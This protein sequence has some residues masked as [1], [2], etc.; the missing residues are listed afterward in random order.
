MEFCE[1]V[2]KETDF[3]W[4]A[5]FYHPF[6]Q[7]I[8]DGSLPLEKFKFY[9]LQDAYYLKH[10]TKVL[11]LAAAKA[12]TDDDVQ[13]FLQTA[14]FIH[15]AELELHRTTFKELGVT[16]DDVEHFEPAPA[17]Y[18]YVSHMYNAVHNGDV[19]EAFAAIL[20]CPWLY[21]E[22]GQRLKDA[23]PNVPL[24][25]Q[26]IALYASDEMLQNIEIQKSMLNRYAKEQ[27][28]KLKVLQEHFKRSCYYEWMFWEMPWTKQSWEQGVYVNEPAGNS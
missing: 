19:A 15:D 3:Y 12:T 1:K 8:A 26:W 22:I 7:G 9:M 6:V 2:R 20:P 4:E 16:A 13:Y 14:K 21:Q 25:D 18:N 10:Y 5:S 27:P 11:A 17:A 24:Y 28:A 23:R